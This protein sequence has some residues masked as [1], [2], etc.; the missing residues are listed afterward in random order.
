MCPLFIR[1]DEASVMKVLDSVIDWISDMGG[2]TDSEHLGKF[3]AILSGAVFIL[4]L[5]IC[6]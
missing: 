4:M 1:P 5:F 6:V 3:A 2:E